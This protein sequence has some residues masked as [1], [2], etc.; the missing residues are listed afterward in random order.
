MTSPAVTAARTRVALT[1]AAA[2]PAVVIRLGG[3]ELAPPAQAAVFGAAVMATALL[4]AWAAEAA[5][6]DISGNLATAILAVVAVLPEYAVDL[7]FAYSAGHDPAQAQ[8]AAANMTGSNRLLIG[9][10]WPFVVF[11]ALA[12]Y[13]RRRSDQPNDDSVAANAVRLEPSRRVEVA[14]LSVSSAFAFVIVASGVL[15]WWSSIVL[16][17]LFAFYVWRISRQPRSEPHLTGVSAALAALPSTRRRAAVASLFVVAAAIVAGAAQPFADSLVANGRQLGIDQFLLV[18]W[19]APLASEAPELIVAGLFAW[20]LRGGDALGTLLSSKV[21]QWTLLVGS[22]PLAYLIGGGHQGLPLDSRQSEEFLLTATQALLALAVVVD[23]EVRRREALALL[24]L[25]VLQLPFPQTGIRLGFSAT[26]II[27]ALA[28]IIRR[29]RHVP[30]VMAAA[31]RTR[32]P[33][34]GPTGTTQRPPESSGARK[35]P[36][37]PRRIPSRNPSSGRFDDPSTTA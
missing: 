16:L 22:L 29:R 36:R 7:Y 32:Q 9:I 28:I 37:L 33:T 13:R 25:F 19:V 21:N 1:L 10:G 31:V 4:L 15:A 20:R 27:A 18:Q 6:M 17:G 11:M 26:Y 34:T 2:A 5:Q 24:A 30:P 3:I 14:F 35:R 23:L 12:A 8:F